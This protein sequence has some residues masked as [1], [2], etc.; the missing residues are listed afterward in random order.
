[1]SKPGF[2]FTFAHVVEL[3]HPIHEGIPCWPGDPRV[4]FAVVASFAREGYRLR[5]FSLGEHTA[6]HLHAPAAFHPEGATIDTYPASSLVVPAVVVDVR[7]RAAAEPDYA[8]TLGDLEAWES[9]HGQ[10]PAGVVVLLLTGW[11]DRWDDPP[12][13]LNQDAAGRLHFPGF[14]LEAARWLL[15][16]R[17]VAGLGTDAPGIDPGLDTA[18]SVNRLVLEK[19]RIVLENLTNLDRIP[20]TGATLII[21]ILRLV[22]GSGSPA[23]VF[24]VFDKGGFL[25]CPLRWRKFA[26]K[27]SPISSKRNATSCR[28]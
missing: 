2:D 16:E 10:F 25:R 20:A 6:T 13:F 28:G 4:E 12:A 19:P 15:T 24:A 17:R 3:S 5:R 27:R 9:S 21:G 26:S 23:C 14:G 18:F 8:V 1:M 11:Q 7:P 22:G